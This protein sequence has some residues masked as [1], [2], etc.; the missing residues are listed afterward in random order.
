MAKSRKPVK[1]YDNRDFLRSADARTIRILSEIHE[2][3]SRFKRLNVVDTV[4]FFGSARIQSK[5][6]ATKNFNKFK[7]EGKNKR[8]YKSE[9]ERLERQIAMSRYYEDTVELSRRLTEWSK[10]LTTDEKRFIVCSG[11]GP[12]IM[13]AANKG[14]KLAKGSSI[15]LN[16][17]IPFE[18]FV[19]KYVEPDL[20]FEFHYFFTRKLWF[21]YLAKALVIFPGGFGTMDEMMEMIT[22][23]QTGKTTKKMKIVVYDENFWKR[24]VNFDAL[25][26]YGTI[27][28]SD[29]KIMTFCNTVDDAFNEITEHFKKYYIKNG[30]KNAMHKKNP[31]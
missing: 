15:G 28:K 11:G 16:I 23:I 14:A 8:N 3:A 4:V 2:P 22:L 5:I 9:L 6:N 25:I 24:V 10:S 20:A 12:G 30:K 1:A 21:M 26:E 7:R 18:Q 31:F 17:S 29:M 19:N 13:E 27:S